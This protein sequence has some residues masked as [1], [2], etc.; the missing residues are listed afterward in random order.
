MPTT[1]MH[2]SNARRIKQFTAEVRSHPELKQGFNAVGL[3][4]G[5]TLV[6]AYIALV[7]D[8]PVYVGHCHCH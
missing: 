8:P 7:N 4:Q 2:L 1:I 5:N 3:S 6:Q